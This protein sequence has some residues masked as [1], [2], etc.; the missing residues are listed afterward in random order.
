MRSEI[1]NTGSGLAFVDG[2]KSGHECNF[3]GDP[4]YESAS[5]KIIYWHTY[6]QWAH[7]PTS[8]RYQLINEYHNR[9]DDPII[10]MTTCC[11][12]CKSPFNPIWDIDI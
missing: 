4:I 8:V 6:R 9:I 7:Y 10:S 11:S 3:N 12:I 5:G 1:V 2:I